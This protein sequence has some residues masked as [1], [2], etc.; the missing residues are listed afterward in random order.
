MA[1]KYS[2]LL[3]GNTTLGISLSGI[4]VLNSSIRVVISSKR[5]QEMHQGLTFDLDNKVDYLKG[6]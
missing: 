2:Q 5:Q 4:R 3:N 6:T 1:I